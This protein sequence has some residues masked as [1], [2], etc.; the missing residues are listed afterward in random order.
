MFQMVTRTLWLMCEQ[1]RAASS[2]PRLEPMRNSWPAARPAET[3]SKDQKALSIS[4]HL[5]SPSYFHYDVLVDWDK[6]RCFIP[7]EG[8]AGPGRGIRHQSCICWSSMGRLFSPQDP[9]LDTSPFSP[10]VQEYTRLYYCNQQSGTTK[11]AQR[12]PFARF[13]CS[14]VLRSAV[15]I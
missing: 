15:H 2:R 1:R 7:S 4:D 8:T 3:E 9:N 10:A 5:N 13:C 11:I 6:V 12:T 14:L